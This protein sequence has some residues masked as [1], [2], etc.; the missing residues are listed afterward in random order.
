MQIWIKEPGQPLKELTGVHKASC[1]DPKMLYVCDKAGNLTYC[2][3]HK[4]PE[5]DRPSGETECSLPGALAH[6]TSS[7]GLHYCE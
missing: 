5:K 6:C 2:E 7:R 3:N 1:A 4:V